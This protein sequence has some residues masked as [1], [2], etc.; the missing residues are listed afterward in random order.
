MFVACL[1]PNKIPHVSA[2]IHKIYKVD[3]RHKVQTPANH[4]CRGITWNIHDPNSVGSNVYWFVSVAR[5]WVEC[6]C[7]CYCQH[8]VT[9]CVVCRSSYVAWTF[10]WFSSTTTSWKTLHVMYVWVWF[11]WCAVWGCT[12]ATMY[13][14]V[15]NKH[16]PAM[17][18]TLEH[19][20]WPMC[21]SVVHTRLC[22][23]RVHGRVIGVCL[24]MFV[25]ICT[26]VT[27]NQHFMSFDRNFILINMT[28]PCENVFLCSWQRNL[29]NILYLMFYM[30]TEY[31]L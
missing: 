23:K 13:V 31:M 8:M 29:R 1:D 14:H 7:T 25:L 19:N 3:T 18:H 5:A 12:C 15:E 4:V 26:C 24:C 27:I 20:H 22:S 10:K 28:R 9:S 2:A 11:V 17:E 16:W 6:V 30:P 21:A